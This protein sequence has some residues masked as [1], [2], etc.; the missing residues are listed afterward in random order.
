MAPDRSIFDEPHH[1]SLELLAVQALT[2]GKS[3]TAF[4]YADR[5]CRILPVPEPHCYVLR[6]EAS[7]R[8]GAKTTAIADLTKALEIAPHDI[9]ANRRMLAWGLGSHQKQAALALIGQER[10]FEVLHKAIEVLWKYGQRNFANISVFENAIEGWAVWQEGAPLSIS[11]SSGDHAAGEVYRPDPL[12]PLAK[13]GHATN[14]HVRRPRS[15]SLQSITLLASGNVFHCAQTAGNEVMSKQRVH[16]GPAATGDHP[17]VTVIVPIYADYGATRRCVESLLSEIESSQHHA[18]FIND[19]TPDPQITNYLAE[20]GSRA[21]VEILTNPRN[22]G[23]VGSVNRAL[24]RVALGDIILL[25]A[26]TIVP[27]GF[28][29]RLAAAAR[30]SPDV[31]TVTPLSNNGEFVS[32]PIA[33]EFNPLG[34]REDV[35]RIDKIAEKVN[36]GVI[37]DIPSGIGF[38]LYIKRA[39]FDAV[40]HLCDDFAPGYL[41][42]ADFCLRARQV[43]FRNVCAPSVYVGHAGS[44]SF[45]PEKRS[46][47]VRNLKLLEQRFPEHRMEC[48]I[49]MDADPLRSAREAIERAA[50][51]PCHPNLLVTGVGPIGA[52]ARERAR[53]LASDSAAVMI[54]EVCDQADRA[55]VKIINAAGGLPQSLEFNLASLRECELLMDFFRNIAPS[56]IEFLDTMNTPF[57]LVDLLLRLRVPYDLFIA[58]ASLLGAQNAHIFAAV[59]QSCEPYTEKRSG[60][61]CKAPMNAAGWT[62]RWRGIA[63]NAQRILAPSGQAEAFVATILPQRSVTRIYQSRSPAIRTQRQATACHLGFVAVRSCADEQRLINAIAGEVGRLRPDISMT[64]IGTTHDDIALMRTSN[65][66]VTGAVDPEEFEPLIDILG[67]GHL[68]ASATQPLFAHPTLSAVFLS[69]VPTAYFQWST[70][71]ANPT[72][73]RPPIDPRSSLDDIVSTLIHWMPE[74]HQSSG[75]THGR[76]GYLGS[77]QVLQAS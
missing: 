15:A 63:E 62:D 55:I 3:Q 37:I 57:Q 69:H 4:R 58:D 17:V 9:A 44:K 10:N 70:G 41:E 8:I 77:E 50:A 40:A 72:N 34:S 6:S 25:N 33:N 31:G 22:L 29:D 59:V 54:V 47:V 65:V 74:T 45:G 51:A 39:C 66:F 24:E 67:I 42:D 12:H 28:I 1:Q 19:A 52:V 38:C 48:A 18:I 76:D 36:A 27:T 14:F 53:E 43:G 26:D 68:F 32:F 7:F 5:R 49:F 35:E 71:H 56:R 16:S 11:I 75:P 46:L 30:S 73:M 13:Y 64:V 23:F 20:L 60:V 21:C 2:D 61:P